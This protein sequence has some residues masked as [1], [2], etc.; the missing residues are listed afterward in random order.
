MLVC[1]WQDLLC[2]GRCWCILRAW[3]FLAGSSPG[4]WVWCP[5]SAEI[6]VVPEGILSPCFQDS[7][8]SLSPP[9]ECVECQ[10]CS[11]GWQEC[12]QTLE[13]A[14]LWRRDLRHKHPG[15][16]GQRSKAGHRAGIWG[17]GLGGAPSCTFH[18]GQQL[19]GIANQTSGFLWASQSHGVIP[20]RGIKGTSVG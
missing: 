4:S 2:K 13:W 12:F 16:K 1:V 6:C 19:L 15:R 3:E 14:M 9:S 11:M 18:G 17:C 7:S 8:S 20:G 10:P 5:P